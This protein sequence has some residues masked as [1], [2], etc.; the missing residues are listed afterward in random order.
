MQLYAKTGTALTFA[1]FVTC[2]TVGL[3]FCLR[4]P[5]QTGWILVATPGAILPPQFGH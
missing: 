1:H 4:L 5:A 3:T 2:S